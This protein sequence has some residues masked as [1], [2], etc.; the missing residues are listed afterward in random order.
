MNNLCS[1]RIFITPH[2]ISSE[3]ITCAISGQHQCRQW[4]CSCPSGR[5][6]RHGLQRRRS[7]P[8]EGAPFS[9]TDSQ[10]HAYEANTPARPW[11]SPPNWPAHV[12]ADEMVAAMDAIGVDG[13]ILVSPFAM[14]RYDGSYAVATHKAYPGRVVADCQLGKIA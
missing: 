6:R 4:R 11:H 14:Y 12:T 5:I 13:A 2:H 9:T 10:V 1:Q 7:I 3:I 8:P